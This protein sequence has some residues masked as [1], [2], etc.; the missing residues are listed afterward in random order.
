MLN[1]NW[2]AILTIATIVGGI[3]SLVYLYEWWK[4][5]K[6][7]KQTPSTTVRPQSLPVTPKPDN[8]RDYDSA[9][10]R[11]LEKIRKSHGY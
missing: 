1:I 7:V 5:R 4:D 10:E 3:G 2:A 9:F 8:P 11:K 6:K